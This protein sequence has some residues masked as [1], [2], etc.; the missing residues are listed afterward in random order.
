MVSLAQIGYPLASISEKARSDTGFS[1]SDYAQW[2]IYWVICVLWMFLENTV[3]WLLTE[4]LPFFMELK[5]AFFLW[6]AH[7]GYKGAALIWQ[8]V[9]PLHKRL[10]DEYIS[11][12]MSVLRQAKIPDT[13]K[14]QG[15]DDKSSASKMG[16]SVNKLLQEA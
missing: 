12:W 16:D 7:P 4:Y 8:H 9:Q 11:G 2:T 13:L 3:F 6:L 14:T 15:N 1:D 5:L 10:D